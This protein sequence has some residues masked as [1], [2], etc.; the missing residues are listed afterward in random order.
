M[1][2]L[3]KLTDDTLETFL[4]DF[5]ET[6]KRDLHEK[7]ERSVHA[8]EEDLREAHRALED[9]PSTAL[10]LV[11]CSEAFYVSEVDVELGGDKHV[12]LDIGHQQVR[13]SHDRSFWRPRRANPDRCTRRYRAV[14][15]LI[16]IEDGD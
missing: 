6:L 16:P 4:A 14:V 2:D 13:L 1:P 10:D 3:K 15:A 5:S 9:L 7:I 12:R 8:V 11:T